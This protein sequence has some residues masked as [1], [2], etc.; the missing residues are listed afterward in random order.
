M[1]NADTVI[2]GNVTADP[3]L[4]YSS[5]GNARLLFSVASIATFRLTANG[6]R[7]LHSSMLQHGVK[8]LKML[9]AF[10]RRDCLLSSLVALNSDHGKIRIADKSDQPLRLQP[11][12][13]QLMFTQ[14]TQLPVVS[15]M[16]LVATTQAQALHPKQ[17][18]HLQIQLKTSDCQVA[19]RSSFGGTGISHI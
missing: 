17:Q 9:Q 1:S 10:W 7:K 8:P 18:S 12:P 4:K 13:W 14:L 19:N 15:M 3:E 11:M 5:N 2:K 6:R 16:A